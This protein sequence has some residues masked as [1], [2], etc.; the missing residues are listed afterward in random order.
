MTIKMKAPEGVASISIGGKHFLISGGIISVPREIQPIASEHGFT[1][2]EE[3]QQKG[4]EEES[5]PE[6]ISAKKPQKSNSKKVA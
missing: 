1:I 2:I 5:K 4:I 3:E 6:L